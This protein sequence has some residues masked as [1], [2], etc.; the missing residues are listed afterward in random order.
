[1]RRC[2]IGAG[3]DGSSPQPR[4]ET[5]RAVLVERKALLEEKITKYRF[6]PPALGGGTSVPFSA[7]ARGSAFWA[8]TSRWPAALPFPSVALFPRSAALGEAGGSPVAFGPLPFELGE[9]LSLLP[10]PWDPAAVIAPD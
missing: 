6:Q 2:S 1:M 5:S 9:A 3:M 8:P 7:S 10:D 4:L